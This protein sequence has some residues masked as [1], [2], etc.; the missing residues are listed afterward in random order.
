M[1][2]VIGENWIINDGGETTL[3]VNGVTLHEG[4]AGAT[5]AETAN[6]AWDLTI[7]GSETI[8]GRAFTP[9]D[10]IETYAPRAAVYEALPAVLQRLDRRGIASQ[11]LRQPGLPAWARISGGRGSY[12]PER[13]TVGAAY[14]FDR[15]TVETGV[16][17]RLSETGDLTGSAS[18]R[19]V[20][21][22]ADVSA[23]TGGGAIEVEGTGVSLMRYEADLRSSARGRLMEGARARARTLRLEAGRRLALRETVHLTPRAWL[24]RTDVSLDGFRDAV[25]SRVSL[26]EAGRP[27]A[28]IGIVAG[29]FHAWEAG[30][31]ILKLRGE[32]GVERTPSDAETGVEVSGERLRSEATATPMKL[33]LGGE[34]RWGRYMLGG[35]ASAS[36]PGSDDSVYAANLRFGMRF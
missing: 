3:L 14:D 25:G 18:L 13:A 21:G 11:W 24:A 20:R 31:R 33:G 23:A 2:Q 9:G 7:S 6:G 32:L 19:H 36:G 16:D 17:F 26:D 1:E 15:F 28:G 4:A 29:R 5:G 34:Y 10:F 30:E 12:G 27:D 35:A 8:Q 22:S